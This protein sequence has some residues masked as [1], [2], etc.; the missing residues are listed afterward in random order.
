MAKTRG[1]NCDRSW[2]TKIRGLDET[3]AGEGTRTPDPIITNCFSVFYQCVAVLLTVF[4]LLVQLVVLTRLSLTGGLDAA[5]PGLSPSQPA[6]L[7]EPYRFRPALL[8]RR[9]SGCAL[10]HR[11]VCRQRHCHGPPHAPPHPKHGAQTPAPGRPPPV[12]PSLE[13]QAMLF[14]PRAVGVGEV[15]GQPVLASYRQPYL[16]E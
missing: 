8:I 3:G 2:T 11:S 15:A 4:P 5:A 16:S 13:H 14:C 1:H 9:Q 12:D 10:F 7:L 6:P